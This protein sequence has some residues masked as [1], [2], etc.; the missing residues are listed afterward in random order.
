MISLNDR[1][2]LIL[3]LEYEKKENCLKRFSFF[4]SGKNKN[5]SKY[6]VYQYAILPILLETRKISGIE[7]KKG[8]KSKVKKL[9]V[10]LIITV[11]LGTALIVYA[12]SDNEVDEVE[13]LIQ[14]AKEVI[15]ELFKIKEE[16]SEKL[17]ETIRD[18]IEQQYNEEL[19]KLYDFSI[20][21]D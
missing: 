5:I 19:E 16:T 11:I 13:I 1:T 10:L 17:K 3:L 7:I 6:N 4:Y 21:D 8:R 15:N 14:E 20:K 9:I 12:T 18:K 2:W